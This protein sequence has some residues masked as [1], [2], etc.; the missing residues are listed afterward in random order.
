VATIKS[1][2][3]KL[4]KDVFIYPFPLTNWVSNIV[5]VTKKQGTLRVCV[6]YRDLNRAYLKDNYATPFIGQ[7]IDECAGSEL[8]SFMDGF[9]SYN[10]INIALANQ[11]KTSII[12]PWGSF[13][14]KKLPFGLK[15]DGATFQR[16][17]FYVFHDI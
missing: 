12:F 11:D 5:L 16:V 13:A 1:E 6:D 17:M 14:Y 3:E 15:N 2:V 8:F 4:L 7:I 10:P 9:P